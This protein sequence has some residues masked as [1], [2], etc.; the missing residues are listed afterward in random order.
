MVKIT[1]VTRLS[2]PT[3]QEWLWA[4]GVRRPPVRAG[5]AA[6]C[7]RRP[8]GA[9]AIL[10]A[11]LAASGPAGASSIPSGA[12]A[13]ADKAAVTANWEAFFNPAT[14]IV[15]KIALLQNG[16]RFAKV[17]AAEAASPITKS[18]GAIVSKVTLTSM[19]EANVGYSLTLGGKPAL[20][21]M[22][23]S[24][25]LLGGVWKV[26]SGSFCALVALQQVKAP[27]CSRSSGAN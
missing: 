11:A 27:A 25:V 16:E 26:G 1:K 24:A 5:R 13:K 4:L 14:P 17:I 15:R 9:F 22:Q 23:G 6:W 20:V 19:T 8:L 3:N 7:M 21:G 2:V 12:A 18:A 10:V